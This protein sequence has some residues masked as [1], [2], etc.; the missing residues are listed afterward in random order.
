MITLTFQKNER[1]HTKLFD[2]CL[3]L[4]AYIEALDSAI[5][6]QADIISLEGT[7]P[8]I[9][10]RAFGKHLE[11]LRPIEELFPA[12]QVP[13]RKVVRRIKHLIP[14]AGTEILYKTI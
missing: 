7:R 9:P 11:P 10:Q 3:T 6:K 14:R 1:T 12:K 5:L 8:Y 13:T 2:E 4:D